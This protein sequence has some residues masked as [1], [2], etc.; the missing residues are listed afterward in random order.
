MDGSISRPATGHKPIVQ[1]VPQKKG[2]IMN[3]SKFEWKPDN[4]G[5]LKSIHIV[6]LTNEK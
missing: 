2:K 6:F 1:I 5:T 3:T 4:L